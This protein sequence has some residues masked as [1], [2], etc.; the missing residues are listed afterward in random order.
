MKKALDSELW[1]IVE[2]EILA[3]PDTLHLTLDNGCESNKPTCQFLQRVTLD[4]SWPLRQLEKW[5]K[6]NRNEFG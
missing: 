3:H 1:L 2:N 5:Q 6:L 4:H